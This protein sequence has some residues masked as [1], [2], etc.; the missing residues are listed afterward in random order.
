MIRLAD[1]AHNS[2]CGLLG[3]RFVRDGEAF[4]GGGGVSVDDFADLEP[5][6]DGAD[7]L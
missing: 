4:S 1:S 6:A 2:N 5:S 3:V 7:F